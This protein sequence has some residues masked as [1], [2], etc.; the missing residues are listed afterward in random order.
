MRAL[1]ISLTIVLLIGIGSYFVYNSVENST[2]Y[3]IDNLSELSVQIN[4]KDWETARSQYLKIEERWNEVKDKWEILIDQQDI[5]NINMTMSKMDQYIKSKDITLSL[6][7]L[8]ALKRL[9]DFVREN[10]SLSLSNI[11]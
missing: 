1:F 4:K 6:A 5:L 7:E 8:E 2:E 9:F 11:F 10:E 3:F